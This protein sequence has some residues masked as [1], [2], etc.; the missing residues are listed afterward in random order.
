MHVLK[1][2]VIPFY[3]CVWTQNPSV[4]LTYGIL[5]YIGCAVSLLCLIV[6]IPFLLVTM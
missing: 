4:S 1:L 6:T 3:I 2:Y 5:S